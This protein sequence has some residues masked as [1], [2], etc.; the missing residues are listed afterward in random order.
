MESM[1]RP[2]SRSVFISSIS[3]KGKPNASQEERKVAHILEEGDSSLRTSSNFRCSP[4]CGPSKTVRRILVVCAISFFTLMGNISLNLSKTVQSWRNAE[5]ALGGLPSCQDL[6]VVPLIGLLQDGKMWEDG[7]L[8][9]RLGPKPKLEKLAISCEDSWEKIHHANHHC[10]ESEDFGCHVFIKTLK[11]KW[12]TTLRMEKGPVQSEMTSELLEM[13]GSSEEDLKAMRSNPDW[14]HV[15][16]LRLLLRIQGTILKSQ[17]TSPSSEDIQELWLQVSAFSNPYSVFASESLQE[18]RM[19]K[20]LNFSIPRYQ[21]ISLFSI[22]CSLKDLDSLQGC[23][24]EKSRKELNKKARDVLSLVSLKLTLLAIAS[25]IYPVAVVSFKEMTSWIQN[26]AQSLKER[27]EDLKQERH[28]AEDLLHQMLPKSVAKQLRK[29]KNVEA[30]NYDQVT[31]FFSDV[32]GFTAISASCSPLQVVEMLNNLYVCFDTRI[33]SYDVY[34]VETIGDAY[35]VVSGLP[36]RNGTKHA[37]EIA[38]MALDL[39]AA[40]RQVVISHMPDRKLELRA[41]IHTGPCVAGV[42]GHKM[43][44]YCL[45]GDTVN[46]ASR[47]ESTSLPQKIHISSATYLALLEDDAY[48]I[49]LRGE[50]D[51]KGKGKMQTYWLLGNKNYSVQNDSLVCHWNPG[52]SQKKKKAPSVASVRQQFDAC[53]MGAPESKKTAGTSHEEWRLMDLNG[54]SLFLPGTA[55][56]DKGQEQENSSGFQKSPLCASEATKPMEE[57]RVPDLLK[58][59]PDCEQPSLEKEQL[60]PGFVGEA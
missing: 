53:T 58:H 6:L 15:A 24:L 60:L 8:E 20:N 40:V 30:E 56:S 43:P 19:E 29:H 36:E 18:C 33:E 44:R 35:M 34:K 37:D 50:I 7:G 14:V 5:D 46:T 11:E 10:K 9:R 17:G 27:T 22:Q 41:G 45:F 32:V 26:Y 3:V 12:S 21:S 49:E 54:R 1:V 23:L 47:M 25:L 59:S 28:L 4:H 39:V 38:K 13:F 42:V 48:D 16:S 57:E 2:S 52:L 31:I 55:A 51:V